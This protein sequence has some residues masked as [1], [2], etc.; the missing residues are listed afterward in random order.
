MGCPACGLAKGAAAQS[1]R[2]VHPAARWRQ[3]NCGSRPRASAEIWTGHARNAWL[4][5]HLLLGSGVGQRQGG[6]AEVTRGVMAAA[7]DFALHRQGGVLAVVAV[8]LGR[9]LAVVGVI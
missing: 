1:L 9:R 4:G 8:A 2:E 7:Q 5:G 6:I 3:E